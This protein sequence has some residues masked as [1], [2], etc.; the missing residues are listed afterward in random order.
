MAEDFP[1][2]ICRSVCY[3]LSLKVYSNYDALQAFVIVYIWSNNNADLLFQLTTRFF[4]Y[5]DQ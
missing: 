3:Q 4:F 2:G 1:G 5:K